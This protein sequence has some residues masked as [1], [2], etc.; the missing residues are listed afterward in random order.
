MSEI[1]SGASTT[2]QM[3]GGVAA[4]HGVGMEAGSLRFHMLS[5]NRAAESINNGRINRPASKPSYELGMRESATVSAQFGE[6]GSLSVS[7]AE[8]EMRGI[9]NLDPDH[10]E[11]VEPKVSDA[12]KLTQMAKEEGTDEAFEKLA[13]D[14]NVFED[15][16]PEFTEKDD[17]EELLEEG[18]EV[19]LR[20]KEDPI[21]TQVEDLKGR[22]DQLIEQNNALKEG[23][24]KN[25]EV[26]LQAIALSREALAILE[27]LLK[28]EDK[29]EEEMSMAEVLVRIVMALLNQ[30]IPQEGDGILDGQSKE[31]RQHEK[32]VNMLAEA[33]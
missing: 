20:K 23:M 22:I 16:K 29:N 19:D 18:E 12:E 7:Q 21:I 17:N 30:F 28:K 15:K 2:G 9:R 26:S 31:E 13:H 5:T 8:K 4:S 1:M 27:K 24:L 3:G 25:A 10:K 33:A 32:E 14:D 6:G 11:D